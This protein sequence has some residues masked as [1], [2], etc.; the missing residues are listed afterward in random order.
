MRE[1]ASVDGGAGADD[2]IVGGVILIFG[3][4]WFAWN[5]KLEGGWGG[6]NHFP[7][8]RREPAKVTAPEVIFTTN[9]TQ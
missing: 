5:G 8:F 3:D 2:I 7:L 9:A 4:F 1:E 6:W